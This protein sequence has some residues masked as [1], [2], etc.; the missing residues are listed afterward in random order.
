[1]SAGDADHARQRKLLSH[2]FS[3]Q[4]LRDQEPLLKSYVDLLITQLRKHA[5]SESG[6]DMVEWLTYVT[7]DVVADL[8]FGSPFG[9]LANCEPHPWVST[10][11]SGIK[12]GILFVAFRSMGIPFVDSFLAKFISPYIQAKRHEQARYASAAVGERLSRKTSRPD[13]LANFQ[14]EN[15]MSQI[16]K[17]E[18]DSIF[19]IVALAGCESPATALSGALYH[20]LSNP[21]AYK[22]LRE[23]VGEL[24]NDDELTIA[25]LS[26]LP[27]LRAVLDESLRMYPPVPAAMDRVVPGKGKFVR[28]TPSLVHVKR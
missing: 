15:D 20:L 23:E 10:F 16:S 14:R 1:M 21:G 13:F 18:I 8:S 24:K 2:A 22:K 19:T 11:K 3:D 17:D 5:D 26:R 27:Y 4:A 25:N 6:T 28:R 12:Q 7:F 9:N